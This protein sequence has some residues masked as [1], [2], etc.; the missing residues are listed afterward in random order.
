MRDVCDLYV[1]ILTGGEL[2]AGS[3]R[4]NAGTSQKICLNIISTLVMT[5]LGRV[6]NGLMI[7]M[8]ASNKKLKK[9]ENQIN[10]FLKNNKQ[11]KLI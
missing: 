9:R 11:S 4:L 5:K 2:V 6:K 7:N 3:T 8:I 1:P 10:K